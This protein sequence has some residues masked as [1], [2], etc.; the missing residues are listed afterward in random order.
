MQGYACFWLVK[1]LKQVR[2]NILKWQR[3][4]KTNTHKRI[5]ATKAELQICYQARDYDRDKVLALEGALTNSIHG[6]E[7]YW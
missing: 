1:K 3:G 5:E 2:I 7:I 6:E 4:A